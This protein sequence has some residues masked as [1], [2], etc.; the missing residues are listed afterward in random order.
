MFTEDTIESQI[1]LTLYAFFNSLLL[2]GR[3]FN[4]EVMNEKHN[5]ILEKS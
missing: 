1:G 4:D 5:E 3:K 2:F